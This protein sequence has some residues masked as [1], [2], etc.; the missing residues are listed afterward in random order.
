MNESLIAA[1]MTAI[2]SVE[3]S[4]NH[5]AINIHDGGSPSYGK[6]QI[7]LSTARHMGF[8]GHITELWLNPEVNRFY[9]E[10]YFRYQLERYGN[11]SVAIAAYNSG[12]VR[13]GKIRNT[14]YVAKVLGRLQ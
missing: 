8:T 5:R 14:Q 13:E 9:A 3:S 2:C 7:K 12:S 10:K 11:V 6:C 4:G 1:V